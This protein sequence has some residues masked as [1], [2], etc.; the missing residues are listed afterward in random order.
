LTWRRGGR[1]ERFL[2]GLEVL[3]V[4]EHRLHHPCSSPASA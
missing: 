4:A 2:K 3:L 1:G